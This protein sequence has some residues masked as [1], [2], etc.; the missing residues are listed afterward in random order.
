MED[1]GGII[2]IIEKALIIGLIIGIAS[3]I[4]GTFLVLRRLALIGDGLAHIAFSGVIIGAFLGIDPVIGSIILTLV[5]AYALAKIKEN[6]ALPG[7]L[8]LGILFSTALAIG[9]SLINKAHF[10]KD[11]HSY[12]FGNILAITWNDIVI[13]LA[14]LIMIAYFI[15]KKYWALVFSTI[16]DEEA[17]AYS[18]DSSKLNIILLLLTA[19]FVVV[20]IRIVGI[21][22]IS[23]F[24]IIPP[25]VAMAISKSFKQ[26]LLVSIGVAVVSVLTGILIS[27]LLDISTGGAIILV[28]SSLFILG[29]LKQRIS[30]T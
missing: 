19:I 26:A 14:L 7:D 3:A 17:K 9:I 29:Q 8:S 21:L 24:I 20:A 11:V 1:I 5:S 6:G 22:L 2:M 16:S 27:Y 30:N 28:S 15:Y 23:A 13:A 4:L 10:T 12:L 18:I 25:A